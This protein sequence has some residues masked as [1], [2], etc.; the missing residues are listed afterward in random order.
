LPR[1]GSNSRFPQAEKHEDQEQR[2]QSRL[3]F[4]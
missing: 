2:I 4:A 3:Q 1:R